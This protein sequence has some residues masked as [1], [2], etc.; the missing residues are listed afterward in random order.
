M[1][2]LIK[3]NQALLNGYEIAIVCEQYQISNTTPDAAK[4]SKYNHYHDYIEILYIT[5]GLLQL[6]TGT[7]QIFAKTGDLVIINAKVPHIAVPCETTDYRVIKF[8]PQLL[9]SSDFSVFEV[10]YMIPFVMQSEPWLFTS[11]Q[12]STFPLTDTVNHIFDEWVDKQIGYELMLRA[13]ILQLFTWIIRYSN[14]NPK[15]A[16]HFKESSDANANAIRKILALDSS[17]LREMSCADAAVHCN[18][19]YSY[20]SRIFKRVTG[21]SYK[22][23]IL[24]LRINEADRLLSGT[25]K[26]ITEIASMT[27]FSSDA[28][29]IQCFHEIKGITPR[30]YREELSRL[31]S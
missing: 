18:M 26:T 21:V 24:Q 1:E 28:Y 15:Y 23:Y 16:S 3:E 29:F 5:N 17:T 31:R 10:K 13:N 12:T 30:K 11:S 25:D 7:N 19:S 9:Y 27:G 8:L 2:H 14:T 20:F 4:Y 22:N 6:I